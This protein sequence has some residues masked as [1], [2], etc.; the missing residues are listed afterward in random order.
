MAENGKVH[1]VGRIC[2]KQQHRTVENGFTA[3]IPTPSPPKVAAVAGERRVRTGG[4]RGAGSWEERVAVG[5]RS[6]SK[7]MKPRG[8]TFV[9]VTWFLVCNVVVLFA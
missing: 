1:V 7:K 6:K 4:G 5:Q 3:I 9:T 8:D 2:H